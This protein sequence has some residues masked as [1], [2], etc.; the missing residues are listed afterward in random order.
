[1]D[2]NDGFFKVGFCIYYLSTNTKNAVMLRG[3]F[4]FSTPNLCGKRFP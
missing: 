2:S 4:K 1:M 3:Y